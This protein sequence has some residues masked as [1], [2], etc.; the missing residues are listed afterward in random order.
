MSQRTLIR[1][2]CVLTLGAITQNFAKADVLI[3][4]DKVA[5]IGSD[6]RVRDADVVDAADTIVMPGFVDTHRHSWKSLFRNTGGEPSSEI[7]VEHHQPD[8]VYAATL[9]G[10]LGAVEAGT[11]TVVDW[12]DIPIG[13]EYVEAALQAHSDA[14]IRTVFVHSAPASDVP[15]DL[16]PTLQQLV[17]DYPSNGTA[18]TTIALGPGGMDSEGSTAEWTLARGLGVR[19]HAHAGVQPS[20]KGAV[21]R[22]GEQGL[23]GADVTLVHCVHLNDEDLDAIASNGVSVALT[24]STE[25]ADGLGIP[26]LQSLL[27]REIAPGLGVDNERIA[28]GDIL[29]QMRVMNSLQ[30]AAYFDLKL[31]GKAGLPNLLTTRDMIRYATAQGASAVGLGDV[32]GS[33][34]VGKQA[35]VIVLRTDRP[36][37]FPINDPIGAVVWGVDTS[38]LDSVFV[39]GRALMR[40]GKLSADVD[41]ARALALSARDRVASAAGF[42]TDASTRWAR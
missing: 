29:A 21:A 33:L 12:A 6:L 17:V 35:D 22:L 32:T 14:G 27:D 3:E 8:D 25:M 7:G 2:G 28:P 38:N 34:E 1:G 11:T 24:P 36:N 13:T 39:A 23:L 31:S 20:H 42:L 16:E 18:L 15:I 5:E 10:L 4:D 26:P 9:A 19:I 30:H 40:N 37:I 41:R